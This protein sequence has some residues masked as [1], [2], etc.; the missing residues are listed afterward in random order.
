MKIKR[1]RTILSVVCALSVGAS[2]VSALTPA[3]A[4]KALGMKDLKA[5]SVKET[6]IKGVFEV[7]V[8]AGPRKGLILMDGAGKYIIQGQ[9]VNINT[10]QPVVKHIKEF[11]PPKVFK[12]VDVKSLPIDKS[13]VIGNRKGK[14]KVY[15]FT[16]P[17]CPYCR[18][19]HPALGKLA[20]AMPEAAIHIFVYPLT[21]IHP[22]AYDKARY[23]LSHKDDIASL[24]AAFAG[25]PIPKPAGNEGKAE[26]DAI[27]RFANANGINGTPTVLG[28]DGQIL[29]TGGN[30][31]EVMKRGITKR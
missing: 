17:D 26:V 7:Y 24:D 23:L 27:I 11:P 20:Q 18:S 29:A 25:K 5:V 1:L 3:E 31:V 8:T 12:G 16:D 2:S 10:R 22:K 14:D 19:L 30:N 15:V 13:I 9:I 4:E 28:P 6:D 21:S